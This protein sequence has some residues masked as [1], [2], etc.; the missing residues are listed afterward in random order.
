MPEWFEEGLD[1][2]HLTEITAKGWNKPLTPDVARSMAQAHR[3]ATQLLGVP[4]DQ[5]MRVPKD[6]SDPLYPTAFDRIVGLS[7]PKTAD[8]YKFDGIAF[9]DGTPLEPED[10]SFVR[11]FAAKNKLPVSAARA[12]AQ[13]L[14]ARTDG[15][16]EASRNAAAAASTANT[17]A[18]TAA[19][20]NDQATNKTLADQAIGALKALG[21]NVSLDGLD[22]NGYV[23]AMNGL[24]KLA[25]PLR[26]APMLGGGGN[27]NTSQV[28]G[29]TR[30]D[31]VAKY[32]ELRLNQEWINKALTPGTSEASY[33]SDLQRVMA[34]V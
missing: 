10:I 27:V 31:A 17:T 29:M 15:A 34:G 23:S 14:V 18:L 19:W 25:G 32:E 33:F 5:L 3:A 24:V 28:T 8:E 11:D 4:T 7:V 30:Q 26:E 2:D 21:V 16:D 1:A 22:A 13:E 9:K 12:L 20:G 6:A